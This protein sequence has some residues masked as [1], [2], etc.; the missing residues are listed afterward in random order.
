MGMPMLVL[1]QRMLKLVTGSGPLDEIIGDVHCTTYYD[2]STRTKFY[3]F[4]KNGRTFLVACYVLHTDVA[5]DIIK[6]LKA[7]K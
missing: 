3:V 5:E 2:D 7:K 4:Q 1:A 6:S